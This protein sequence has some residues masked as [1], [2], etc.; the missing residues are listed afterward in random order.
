MVQGEP[1][2]V[3]L[4]AGFGRRMGSTVPKP[5]IP[6]FGMPIIE[7]TIRALKQKN[8]RIIVVYSDERIANY[9]RNKFPDII[10]VKNPH[11]EKENGYSLFLAEKYVN[12]DFFLFMGD[13]Y[14]GDEF[15]EKCGKIYYYTTAFV[16]KF[17]LDPDEATKVAVSGRNVVDI[18]K[19]LENYTY[20]DTGMFYCKKEIFDYARKMVSE[21]DT[22]PL[23]SIFKEMASSELLAYEV[24]H[25]DWIDI[26]TPR[27]LKMAEEIIKRRIMK[28]EDGIIA[29]YI[30]RKISLAISK[31]IIRYEFLTPNILTLISFLLGMLSAAM[32]FLSL[33]LLGGIM[34]QITSIVDGCDGEVARIKKMKSEF[35]GALDSITDR[36][37]DIF[38]VLGMAYAYGINLLSFLA[39]F[40]A[41]TGVIIFSYTW[42]KTSVRFRVGGRDLR[43]FVIM[44]GGILSVISQDALIITLLFVGILSHIC[45]VS[46]LLLFR[47]FPEGKV[48]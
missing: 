38:I 22:V 46:S 24:V 32:F 26:D 28:G 36:Y 43:L 6:L 42:H 18:G 17:S 37:V 3:I 33:P 47:K 21:R 13:H 12:G 19:K 41:A 2:A 25:D 16:S 45:A 7:H 20:F 27:E 11:P 34:A 40:T 39:L 4:A 29:K 31:K 15:F 35:G 30:N 23:S 44:L 9:L 48:I 8:C 1:V 10:L 5:L 14:F